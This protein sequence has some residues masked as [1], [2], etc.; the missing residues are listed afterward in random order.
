MLAGK[1]F[2]FS[3]IKFVIVIVVIVFAYLLFKYSFGIY[4]EWKTEN[5]YYSF[6]MNFQSKECRILCTTFYNGGQFTGNY[7]YEKTN[8]QIKL[9]KKNISG[10][11]GTVDGIIEAICLFDNSVIWYQREKN[12]IYLYLSEQDF[13]NNTNYLMLEHQ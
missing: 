6:T 10:E 2:K 3:C 13:K 1:R 4:G 9:K 11:D 5:N 12:K 8:E 7:V